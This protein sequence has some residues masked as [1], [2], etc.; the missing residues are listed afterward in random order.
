[1]LSRALTL[2]TVML[3]VGC[4]VAHEALAQATNLEA[5]KSPSQ[6]FA[7]TCTACH[8]SPHG[9]LKTVPPGSLSSFLRQHYTTSGEMA[10]VLASYLVSNG[11]T[12]T[13]VGG[14]KDAKGAKEAKQEAAR[15]AGPPDQLDRFGRRLRP[16]TA[17]QEASRPET[18]P[19]QAAKPDA[20]GLATPQAEPGRPAHNAKRPEGQVPVQA[21]GDRGPDGRRLSAKHRLSRRGKLGAEEP[22]KADTAKEEPASAEPSKDASTEPSKDASKSEASARQE[23]GKSEATKP[24]GEDQ[25]ETAK[26]EE[27][28][29]SN[30]EAPV[31]R[32]DPV[33]PVTSAPPATSQAAVS[34][35]PSGG[36]S[37][38]RSAG[39][40]TSAQEP[41][42]AVTASAPP[43]PQVAPAGP[44]APPISQ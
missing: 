22:P 7:G 23:S 6:I 14:A 37:E 20:D 43:L 41:P 36:T 33:P 35:Q 42:P 10:G 34:A 40:S 26:V 17:T 11:A 18:E 44:P 38:P 27:P 2:A 3:L 19:R 1:M 29:Q 28:K 13:R 5:G 15:P 21:E 30:G 4:C 32:A 9:L 25:P 39:S 31:A 8:K 24:S 12:D 16:A